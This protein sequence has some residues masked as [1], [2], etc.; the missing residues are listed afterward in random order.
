MLTS[1]AWMRSRFATPSTATGK[2]GP[3]WRYS[4]TGG[5]SAALSY[6]PT[7]KQGLQGLRFAPGSA[8]QRA[9]ASPA[10]ACTG[11]RQR[12]R[13]APGCVPGLQVCTRPRGK[14]PGTKTQCC[15]GVAADSPP[16][17]L[18][19]AHERFAHRLT[20]RTQIVV[21]PCEAHTHA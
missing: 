17:L 11:W 12:R 5:A 20:D 19:S 2:T 9:K 15:C 1:L 21:T 8:G 14:R 10:R 4:N 6:R 18:K 13:C 3:S 7:R 16:G